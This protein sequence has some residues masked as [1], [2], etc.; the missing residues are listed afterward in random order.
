MDAVQLGPL[1][2]PW[3]RVQVA[4]ALLVLVITGEVLARK[5]DRRFSPWAYNAV[6]LGLVGARLGFV[7]ENLPVFAKDPLS[8]LY[9]WQG[10]FD[11]VWGILAGGGYTLMV[12]PKHLWRYALVAALLAGLTAG[13]LFTRGGGGQE[14]R[15]PALEL[16]ALGGTP[17]NLEDF[18]GKPLV[19]NTWATWCPPCRR[20]LPMMVRLSQEH[21][22]VRFAFVSQGEGPAVVKAFLEGQGLAPEWVLLD[23]ETRVSQALGVQGLP[24]TFFF[25]SSGRLVARHLGE[26]SE[27]LLL[28]YLRV[29]R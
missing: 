28:G 5:V 25:D 18:R 2:I 16:S 1:A 4:L 21:P 3:T 7:L 22:G 11:P 10:G 17:V 23:P 20:E 24:T 14:V 15:L 6:F 8:V 9:V 26:L 13:V 19:L 12:V 27:A 29:L